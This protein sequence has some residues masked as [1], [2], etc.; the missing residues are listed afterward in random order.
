MS[1]DPKDPFEGY[2]PELE[3]WR[4]ANPVEE[5]LTLEAVVERM[6]VVARVLSQAKQAME[7]LDRRLSRV[8][9]ALGLGKGV[10]P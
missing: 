5:E 3:A 6:V 7:S 9:Q 1:E 2:N 10:K 4:I 8:E